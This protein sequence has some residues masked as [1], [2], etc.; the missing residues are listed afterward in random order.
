MTRL[1]LRMGFTAFGGPAAHIAILRHETI[2]RRRWLSERQ[3]LDY[4]SLSNLIPGPNS[5][6]LIMHLGALRGGRRGLVAAGLAFITP[7]ALIML[8]LAYAYDRWGTRPAAM[9]ILAG[10]APALIVVMLFALVPLARSTIR[11]A[12]AIALAAGLAL[13]YLTGLNELVLLAIGTLIY[14]LPAIYA[15]MRPRT[16]AIAAPLVALAAGEGIGSPG[17]ERIFLVFLKIGAVLYGSGYVLIA[18]L[19]SDLVDERHWITEQQLLDAVAAGQVTP[20]PLF[21]TATFVGY[22]VGGWAGAVAASVGIFLP[23]FVLVAAT[24]GL[25]ERIRS[26]PA[27]SRLLDGLNLASNALLIGVLA[28]LTR[29]VGL[30]GFNLGVAALAATALAIGRMGPTSVLVLAGLLGALRHAL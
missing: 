21:S 17:V 10:I 11:S 25:V 5:T 9:G 23:A 20:G 18:F 3:F 19:Q 6:E 24:H 22:L 29:S 4:L 8:A 16:F 30:S 27:L 13:L 2:A 12:T 7:A 14:L 26:S 28:T 15:Y 1:A